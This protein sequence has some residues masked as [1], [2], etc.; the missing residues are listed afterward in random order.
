MLL[1][2]CM[3]LWLEQ[4]SRDCQYRLHTMDDWDSREPHAPCCLHGALHR[5]P[6]GVPRLA[7]PFHL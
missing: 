2:N 3:C 5:P 6:G 7:G 4:E 1:S